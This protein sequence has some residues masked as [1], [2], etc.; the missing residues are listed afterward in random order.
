MSFLDIFFGEFSII[1]YTIFLI[2]FIVIV[3]KV[4]GKYPT[5]L[6][7]VENPRKEIKETI[8]LWMVGLIWIISYVFLIGFFLSPF[9]GDTYFIGLIVGS[10]FG[11]FIPILFV[12]YRIKWT[13]KDFGIINK[14]ESWTIVICSVTGYLALGIYSFFRLEPIETSWLSLLLLFYSNAFLEEF[15]YR[16]IIQS[17]LERAIG[18]KRA[19][20]YQAILFTIV[21][22][23]ANI[24]RLIYGGNI[25]F[26]IWNFGFQFLHGLNYGIIYMKSRNLFPSVICHYLTNWMGA[27]IMLFL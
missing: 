21:H 18:Q 23:P 24:A 5:P 27:V 14:V 10:I 7:R 4:I 26:F 25:L 11:L 20:F 15:F 3:Y 13:L 12:V 19:L 2:I 9:I 6:P 17:K 1:F 22:F 8:F 16:G